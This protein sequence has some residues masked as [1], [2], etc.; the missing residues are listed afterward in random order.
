M[1][2][3]VPGG[4]GI[5]SI[6][7]LLAFAPGASGQAKVETPVPLDPVQA[8][9]EARLLVAELLA[10]KPGENATNLGRLIIQQNRV[11]QPEVAVRFETIQTATNWLSV[12]ETVPGAGQSNATRLVVIH[13]PG[14]PNQ[15]QLSEPAS[16]SAPRKLAG[17][18][19]MVPFAGSDFWVADLGF[20]FLSWPRQTLLKKEMKNNKFCAVLESINPR[21]EGQGYSRVVS[22]ITADKPHGPAHADAYDISGKKLKSFDPKSVEKVEGVYQLHSVEM[23]NLKARSRTVME[24]NLDDE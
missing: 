18:Q 23:R 3:Q 11:S 21:P 8:E 15:Y 24:F 10:Q 6:A 12:Y 22:W 7:F 2:L 17:N 13:T 19:T 9:R 14:Q 1:I 4:F 5:L 20:E 16:A